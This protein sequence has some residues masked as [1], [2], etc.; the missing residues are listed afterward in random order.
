MPPKTASPP[1]LIALATRFF[2][3]VTSASVSDALS[4][5]C[6]G[7]AIGVTLLFDQTPC[8]SGWPSGVRG[9]FHALVA[10]ALLGRVP[11]VWA[12]SDAAAIVTAHRIARVCFMGVVCP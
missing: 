3:S 8:K 2:N 10:G 12:A 1:F 11:T 4:F 6:V 9:T 7:R 5:H